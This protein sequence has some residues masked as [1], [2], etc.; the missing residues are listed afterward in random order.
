MSSVQTA[1]VALFVFNRPNLTAQMFERVREARPGRLLIVADGPRAKRPED[2][3]LCEQVRRMVA[4]ADWPCELLT[5]FAE[6]NLGCRRRLSSGLDWVFDQCSEAIV[7]EDDCLPSQSFFTFCTAMLHRYRADHRVMHVSGDNF[8]DG[9]RR[10]SGSYFFSRYPLSWGWA[11]WKRAW[12][13]YDVNVA[14]WPTASEER[15][16]RTI[17]D[18]PLERRYWTDIFDHV[19]RGEIDTW[20]YQ[21]LF[22]CWRHGG[23]SIQPNENLVTNIGAGQDATHFQGDHS[24]LGIPIRELDGCVHPDL[25]VRNEQADRYTFDHHIGGNMADGNV[26][27]FHQMRKTIALRTRTKRVLRRARQTLRMTHG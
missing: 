11:T 12:R 7:L 22:T 18:N 13:F 3:Q 16:L 10:G 25:V 26:R 27:W 14:A 17:L 20:D 6:E 15:W 23:L 9:S 19:H 2:V 21:W 1:P 5:N 24:T 4:S 8:Q